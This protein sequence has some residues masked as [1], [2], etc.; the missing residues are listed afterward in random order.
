VSAA[1]LA[2]FVVLVVFVFVAH[3]HALVSLVSFVSLAR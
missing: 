1:N 3:C 2:R